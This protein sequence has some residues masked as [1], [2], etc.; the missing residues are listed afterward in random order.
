MS[1]KI[2][3]RNSIASVAIEDIVESSKAILTS[4]LK[5]K[6]MSN[7][8][9]KLLPPKLEL[10][11]KSYFPET[12]NSDRSRALR[13]AQQAFD[14]WYAQHVAP[15]FANAVEVSCNG[16]VWLDDAPKPNDTH[17]GLLIGVRPIERGVE[18]SEVVELLKRFY[19][20]DF[21]GYEMQIAGELADRLEREGLRK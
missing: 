12:I 14:A 15:L 8:K 2:T 6:A 4:A 19:A 9:S 1:A 10:Q 7:L 17:V 13:E 5:G 11:P 18:I 21:S 3:Y 20:D 16:G